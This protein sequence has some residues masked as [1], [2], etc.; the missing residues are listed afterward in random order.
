MRH[1]PPITE[2]EIQQ[3][4]SANVYQRGRSYYL[5]DAV[6]RLV[7]RGAE[8]FAEVQGS[9]DEPYHVRMTLGDAGRLQVFCTCPYD[10]DDVCKH[11]VAVLLVYL[12]R[13]ETVEERPPVAE[14]LQGLEATQLRH[15]LQRLVAQQ[16]ALAELLEA[17]VQMLKQGPS[18]GRG[19]Q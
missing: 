19:R 6:L 15:I 9:A 8:L 13:P 14:V 12:H 2:G 10:Y 4:A 5:Q 11:S 16:P 3:L 18:R 7:L 1:R 17:E